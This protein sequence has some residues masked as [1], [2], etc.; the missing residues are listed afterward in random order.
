MTLQH[1]ADPRV[2]VPE[3]KTF[4]AAAKVLTFVPAKP[5]DRWTVDN[6]EKVL[7]ILDPTEFWDVQLA[8]LLL[9]LFFTFA[10]TETPLS[11]T[12]AGRDC[13]DPNEDLTWG[14][15]RLRRDRTTQGEQVVEVRFKKV[16]TDQRMERPDARGG[17]DWRVVGEVD[18]PLWS[19]STWYVRLLSFY[20]RKRGDAEPFFLDPKLFP[21]GAAPGE[22]WMHRDAEPADAWLYHDALQAAKEAQRRAGISEADIAAFHG[23]RVE[24]WN[25][26]KRGNGEAITGA[27]GGWTTK[28]GRR[29]YDRFGMRAAQRISQNMLRAR[30]CDFSASSADDESDDSDGVAPRERAAGPPPARLERAHLSP[31]GAG[32]SSSP[33]AAQVRA[34]VISASGAASEAPT[35][36][37]LLLPEG[38]SVR[39][40]EAPSGVRYTTYVGPNGEKARSRSEVWATH[41]ARMSV[42]GQSDAGA[43]AGNSV[44]AAQAAASGGPASARKKKA[45]KRAVVAESGPVPRGLS[46]GDFVTYHDRPSARKEPAGRSRV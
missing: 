36:Q 34:P 5:H 18:D 7:R 4:M 27:H 3:W 42:M 22:V 26:S 16:K 9:L 33:A 15:V 43:P 10:R 20:G 11:K 13:F 39:R 41:D 19:L 46:L 23:L 37:D 25:L 44:V 35:R 24:A 8:C 14:D 38:W 21:A 31:G 30:V 2:A 45:P 29:R 17:G 28:S 6:L 12:R 1:Q 32:S 40:R